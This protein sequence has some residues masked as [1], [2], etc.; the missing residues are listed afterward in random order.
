M[1]PDYHE[2]VA[3]PRPGIPT[4]ALLTMLADARERALNASPDSAHACEAEI[5]NLECAL[6]GRG[7]DMPGA[8]EPIPESLALGVLVRALREPDATM[9]TRA[10]ERL[11][12]ADYWLAWRRIGECSHPDLRIHCLRLLLYCFDCGMHGLEAAQRRQRGIDQARQNP[13]DFEA[14]IEQSLNSMF[15]V[16]LSRPS[17]GGAQ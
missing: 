3:T 9:A 7:V 13:A 14:L 10:L 15:A 5:A 1:H 6:A 16:V 4:E 8:P 11:P 12:W 2:G 17:T